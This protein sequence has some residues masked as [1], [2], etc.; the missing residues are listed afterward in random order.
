MKEKFENSKIE[1]RKE[2]AKSLNMNLEEYDQWRRTG[3]T[4]MN[5]I[6]K[7]RIQILEIINNNLLLNL[8]VKNKNIFELKK[9]I[10]FSQSK[11]L[12]LRGFIKR[13]AD[14]KIKILQKKLESIQLETMQKTQELKKE[15]ELTNEIKEKFRNFVIKKFLSGNFEKYEKKT[16]TYLLDLTDELENRNVIIPKES[17]KKVLNFEDYKKSEVC[18]CGKAKKFSSKGCQSCRRE[19]EKYNKRD[20]VG[21]EKSWEK[22]WNSYGIT[23][24]DI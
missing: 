23:M 10:S 14:G 19:S 24:E 22:V 8:D 4:P 17:E 20:N 15:S 13:T 18:V 9:Q 5:V 3:K 16:L 1:K 2:S 11:I 12:E 6:L 21:M 7:D